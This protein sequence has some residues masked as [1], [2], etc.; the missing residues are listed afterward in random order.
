MDQ[1]LVFEP[2]SVS[3]GNTRKVFG[4][5]SARVYPSDTASKLAESLEQD[6]S[7]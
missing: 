7:I 5:S 1:G 6:I 3:G 4:N 2:L